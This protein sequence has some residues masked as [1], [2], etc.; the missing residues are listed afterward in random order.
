MTWKKMKKFNLYN[1]PIFL[2]LLFIK[3]IKI[4]PA[5]FE[6]DRLLINNSYFSLDILLVSNVILTTYN[7]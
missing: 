6:T 5:Y 1:L 4:S 3:R 2:E 7:Y